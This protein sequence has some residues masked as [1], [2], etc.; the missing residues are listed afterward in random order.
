MKKL[1]RQA[2]ERRAQQ[3]IEKFI[4][5]GQGV[6]PGCLPLTLRDAIADLLEEPMGF[7]GM[8][9][10]QHNLWLMYATGDLVYYPAP[11]IA[12]AHLDTGKAGAVSNYAFM[13]GGH[14]WAVTEFGKQ[15]HTPKE[16]LTSED[17]LCPIGEKR[18]PLL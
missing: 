1:L 17:E 7:F 14:L 5:E 2:A 11:E 4:R 8:Y 15:I 9:C 13:A 12:Q 6:P 3:L 16:S 10:P 18:N